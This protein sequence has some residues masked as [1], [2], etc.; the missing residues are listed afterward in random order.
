MPIA[1]PPLWTNPA[2]AGLDVPAGLPL[3]ATALDAVA[4]DLALLG[5]ADG[6]S[7]I[8]GKHDLLVNGGLEFWQHPGGPYS[9]NG[10]TTADRWAIALTGTSSLVVS[11]ETVVVDAQSGASAK[12]SYTHAAGGSGGLQQKVEDYPR[13]RGATVTLAA[14]VYT[15]VAGAALSLGDNLSTTLGTPNAVVNGWETIWVT[16][17]LATGITSLTASLTAPAG[18]ATLYFDTATLAVCPTPF[19][20]SAVAAADALARCLRYYE[21]LANDADNTLVFTGNA[22]AGGTTYYF[23]LPLK[24]TKAAAPTVT[25]TG[26]WGV[27]NCGQPT[28]LASGTKGVVVGVQATAAG[29]FS[30]SNGPAGTNIVAEVTTL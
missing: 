19:P 23:T 18:S 28:I 4:S 30:C 5:G 11:Q 2:N 29:Y 22:A 10:A 6:A 16:R 14:R 12:L 8:A 26:T 7:G 9:A 21:R 20:F 1:T 25:V 3:P 15:N 13:L 17:A 27:T 24:V